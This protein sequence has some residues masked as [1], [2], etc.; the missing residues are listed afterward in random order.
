[1]TIRAI[2][3]TLILLVTALILLLM[4]SQFLLRL[5][6]EYS[7]GRPSL[8]I[9]ESQENGQYIVSMEANPVQV[10]LPSESKITIKECWCEEAARISYR[11]LVFR[12]SRKLGWYRVCF[13]LEEKCSHELFSSYSRNYFNGQLQGGRGFGGLGARGWC[14]YDSSIPK[15]PQAGDEWKIVFY[16][17]DDPSTKETTLSLRVK[18]Y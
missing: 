1:M 2:V 18:K 14:V 11:W 9:A 6:P 13:T 8:C 17:P 15:F 4:I 12:Q 16:D 5:P 3:T 7:D 10:T